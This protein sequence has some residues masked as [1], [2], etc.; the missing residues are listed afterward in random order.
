MYS[1]KNDGFSIRDI[2]IQLLFIILFIFILVWLFPTKAS[3]NNQFASI[4]DRLDA[5]TN[6][7]F[8]TNIQTMK[9]AA[10]NY[11]TTERLP[12]KV[13][14][15]K[16]MNLKEMI[17]NHLLVEFKDGNGNSCD[18]NESYVE[19]VKL[20]NEYQLKVNLSC[21][22]ND[23]YIIVH[24]GCY[25]YCEANGVC[26]KNE[27]P[28]VTS[29][30]TPTPTPE[31]KKCSYEY[32]LVTN[33]TW[34]D[35]G[36]WS[37]W[38]TTKVTESEYRKVEMKKEKVVTGTQT[39]VVDYKTETTS[40]I[41]STSTYC[42]AGYE[43]SGDK[44]V[45][46]ATGYYNAK[47]P[48]GYALS[49]GVCYGTQSSTVSTDPVCPTGYTRSGAKCYKQTTGQVTMTPTCPT[50]YTLNGDYCYK[51][52]TTQVTM[53][54]ACPSGYTLNGNYCY[55][56]VTSGG[57]V[58]YTKGSYITTKTGTSVPANNKTYYYETV[59]SDYVYNC[60]S[61][62]SMKWIYTYKVYNT[63]PVT[64]GGTTQTLKVDASCAT[65][66]KL[67][68][69]VCYK[70]VTSNDSTSASCATNYTLS[71]GVCYKTT[72]TT[73]TKDATCPTGYVIS[74]DRCYKTTSSTITKTPSCP[75]GYTLNGDKCYGTVKV[76]ADL[77]T[78][79]S[80]SCPNGG[81]FTLSGK[82]CV[83]TVPVYGEKDVYE[84]VVYYRYKE[85][86]YI[87]GTVDTKW[88][89]SDNDTTLINKGYSLTGNKK[90]S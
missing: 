26:E 48:T 86:K 31:Q 29:N 49:N 78:S 53:T 69:G 66:Y 40:A 75:T 41:A 13:N 28:I 87:S 33:G 70:T 23:A 72:T 15:V 81:G 79:V 27:T 38:S 59:S 52:G 44:C 43:R 5:L 22:D 8:N 30:P 76:E 36:N 68:N 71:N 11:Y 55:K 89:N 65:N 51:T 2:F 42:P 85:R 10:V 1:E 7:I 60:D 90:C 84:D 18:L 50:G 74:G 14:D 16:S 80:Y 3:V 47:C 64:S 58:T 39:V 21:T 82:K 24:L 73:D 61:T 19:V 35:Y 57:T 45:R 17:N 63:V 83:R 34:G 25:D 56:T 77:I 54:P 88:S 4:N 12:E 9:D 32:K 67:S 20:E 46:N 37:S 62:C 6:G